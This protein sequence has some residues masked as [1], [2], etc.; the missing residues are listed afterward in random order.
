MKGL[1]ATMISPVEALLPLESSEKLSDA[2]STKEA[3][4]SVELLTSCFL[5]LLAMVLSFLL[6]WQ[7]IVLLPPSAAAVLLGM[8]G[9]FVLR[10]SGFSKQFRFSPGAQ[11]FPAYLSLAA[12]WF[13]AHP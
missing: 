13:F 2:G 3:Q 12:F 10:L 4:S 1:R 8:A 11:A 9:G 6:K 5:L 7:K